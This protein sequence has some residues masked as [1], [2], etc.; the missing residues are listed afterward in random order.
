MR[1][2]HQ[3]N[4][5]ALYVQGRAATGAGQQTLR[6][7]GLETDCHF[8]STC[9]SCTFFV[10]TIEFRATLQHNVTTHEA[11]G[12]SPRQKIFDGLLDRPDRETP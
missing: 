11:R 2:A 1:V 9:Q 4:Y 5:R 12:R 3:A 7:P 8:E 10:T 6:P